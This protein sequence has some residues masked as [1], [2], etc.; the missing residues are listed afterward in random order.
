MD[1]S[2]RSTRA[3]S[4]RAILLCC[5][6]MLL[7][8]PALAQQSGDAYYEQNCSSCHSIG[9]G[10]LAGP[11]LKDVT[12]RAERQWLL[13]FMRDP[14]RKVAAKDAYALKLREQSQ[15]MAMPAFPDLTDKLGGE[16]LR[17][18]ESRS[19]GSHP[20]PDIPQ[21]S[22]DPEVGRALFIGTQQL[23]GG[24]AA[25]MACHQ[26]AGLPGTGGKLGP[27]LTLIRQRLGGERGLSAWMQRPPTPVMSAIYRDKQL[28]NEE[29]AAL[30]AFF[31]S[32]LEHSEQAREN[33]RTA[34]QLAGVGMSLLAVLV[35]GF[36][37]RGRS[38][39]VRGTIVGKRDGQ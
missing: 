19:A 1:A 14:D 9:G 5:V 13:E 10:Y 31:G 34:V 17:Y 2:D 23:S 32:T 6:L 7:Q 35:A 29:I 18:I 3:D 30:A 24:G 20:Q 26:A 36:V 39:G 25:C 15:G 37:W 27:D 4:A 38:R 33:P 16:V 8:T 21:S 11:D 28:T 22:G 12:R